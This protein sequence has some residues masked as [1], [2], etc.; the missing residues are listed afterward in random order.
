MHLI[1]QI[2]IQLWRPSTLPH[3]EWGIGRNP[4][5]AAD[6]PYGSKELW[7]YQEYIGAD[8]L[9]HTHDPNYAKLRRGDLSGPFARYSISKKYPY[10]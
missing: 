2:H 8:K 3:R 6:R 7:S 5:S 4:A 9:V 10:D 1:K